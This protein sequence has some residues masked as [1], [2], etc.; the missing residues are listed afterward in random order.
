MIVKQL[1][2]EFNF[3]VRYIQSL[4]YVVN[5]TELCCSLLILDFGLFTRVVQKVSLTQ[6]N[7]YIP[8]FVTA[9]YFHN[10]CFIS[11]TISCG[12]IPFK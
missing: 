8:Y 4:F 1:V 5:C 11:P 9:A 7:R 2:I 12:V 6:P 10:V 3:C